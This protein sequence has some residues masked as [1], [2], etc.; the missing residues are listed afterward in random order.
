MLKKASIQTLLS[1]AGLAFLIALIVRDERRRKSQVADTPAAGASPP[2][3]PPASTAPLD[4]NKALFEGIRGAEV[5]Q[6]QRWLNRDGA[7]PKLAVDGIFGPLTK[8]ALEAVKG[9]GLVTLNQYNW[10]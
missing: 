5:E 8:K 6:L 2:S 4:M 10:M 7:T 1:A 3:R 9:V